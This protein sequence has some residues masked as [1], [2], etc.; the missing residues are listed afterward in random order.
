MTKKSNKDGKLAG[1]VS[2]FVQQYARKAYPN[3]DPND[4]TYDRNLEQKIR[5]M[6][7]EVLDALLRQG[8][9]DN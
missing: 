7:P 3:H 6:K 5:R 8:D 9:E 4:R 1:A 2:K